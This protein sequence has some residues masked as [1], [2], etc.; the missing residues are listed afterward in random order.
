MAEFAYNN[1]INATTDYMPF[2]V[3]YGYY[4]RILYKEEV[5]PYSKSKSADKLLAKLRGLMIIS[6][7]NHYHA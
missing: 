3:N 5:N 2:Q 7:E 6:R 4:P 1:T